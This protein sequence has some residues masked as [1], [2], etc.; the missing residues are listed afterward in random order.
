MLCF[1]GDHW[2][3]SRWHGGGTSRSE[4]KDMNDWREPSTV[5]KIES[6]IRETLNIGRNRS[7]DQPDFR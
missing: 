1:S 6:K 2:D 3:E 5:E 4:F 7:D